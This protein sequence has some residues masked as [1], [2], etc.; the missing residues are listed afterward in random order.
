MIDQ[1]T[2]SPS[3]RR[4]FLRRAGLLGLAAPF[5]AIVSPQAAGL[6]PGLPRELLD[7]PIC[8]VAAEGRATGPL[9]K[10][11]LAWNASAICTASAP[12]AK[13][14]GSRSCCVLAVRGALVRDDRDVAAAL[15]RSVLEAGHIVAE[16][17]KI[18]AEIF[19][20]YGGKGSIEDLTAM[21]RSQTHHHQPIGAD[22][23]KEIAR[24]IDELKVVNVIRK[25]TD[26]A[27]FAERVFANVLG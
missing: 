23:K 6:L 25:S 21:L 8:R 1:T 16:E 20:G 18:A 15:T 9:R 17:P 14:R 2:R 26:S 7:P 27:K 3:S 22:L 4:T 12:V 5:G 19:A 10:I 13:E 24:Y 11:T